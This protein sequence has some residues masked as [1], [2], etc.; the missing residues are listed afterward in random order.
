VEYSPDVYTSGGNSLFG[1]G[2]RTIL[3]GATQ[4]SELFRPIRPFNPMAFRMPSTVIGLL[5]VQIDIQGVLYFANSNDAGVPVELLS[6]VSTMK[7]LGL[8]TIDPASG[9]TIT[10]ANP[11]AGDLVFSGSFWGT[12]VRR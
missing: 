8:D 11:T 7:D 1:L 3:A 9:V 6:E 4:Q 5:V 2:Q 12:Q 10:L